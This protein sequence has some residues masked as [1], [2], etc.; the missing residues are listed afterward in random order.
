MAGCS[1]SYPPLRPFRKWRELP[2]KTVWLIEIQMSISS[3]RAYILTRR[4]SGEGD[5]AGREEGRDVNA[6]CFSCRDVEN[7]RRI[8]PMFALEFCRPKDLKFQGCL[9]SCQCCFITMLSGNTAGPV[10]LVKIRTGSLP[11]TLPLP[12]LPPSPFPPPR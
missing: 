9:R 8:A 12:P 2:A 11:R 4:R 10:P 1:C 6:E 7:G 3:V 5:G